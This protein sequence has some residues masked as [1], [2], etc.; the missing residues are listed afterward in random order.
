VR[1][2]LAGAAAGAAVLVVAAVAVAQII[3]GVPNA[4]PR[5]GSPPDIVASGFKLQR[6]AIGDDRLENPA[7]IFARYGYLDD[8]ALQADGQPTKTEPDQ[9]TYLVTKRNPGGPTAGYDYGHR[10]LIQGHELFTPSGQTFKHAYFTRIN[11]DVR[12]PEHRIT[13]LNPLASD[14]TDSGVRSIDGST[15]DPFNGELLFTAEAGNAGGVFG[16]A[17]KWTGTTAPPVKNYDGSMGKAGYEGIHNDKLGNLIIVE[18]VGG[19]NVTD[20]GAAT[21]IKQPNSFVYRFKPKSASD[22]SEGKLQVLQ[23]SVSGTPI[24][25]HNA[26]TDGPQAARDDA[27]G[28]PIKA[29]HSGQS[30]QAKWVTI[31]DTAVDGT[32]GFDAEAAAKAGGV[33]ANANAANKGTPLKRPEN[34]KFV[35]GTDFSSFVFTE[36][37]DTNKIAG[38]YPGAAE[39]AAWGALLRVDLPKAGAD[40]GTVRAIAVGDQT[41][42]SF[43]NITFLDKK[44]ALVG[45]DRGDTL[46]QQ[47]NALDSLWSF[48][49][50][51][52]LNQINADAKRLIAQGR[53]PE[54]TG[55][56]A[57]REIAPTRTHNDG[58]NETT[59]IHVSDGS[60]SPDGILGARVPSDAGVGW[61]PWRIF[62]TDQHGSNTT[63]ELVAVGKKQH[64]W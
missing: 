61:S 25:F 35:P 1:R 40:A 12:D 33:G 38:D 43:D 53:D 34:G 62:F 47:A 4:N 5:S 44:T 56:V 45:E 58:D 29:L 8:A 14:A 17:L 18:D 26:A 15:Y 37:G 60:T 23:V 10:F 63:S 32:A 54:A 31:H 39:R 46:H 41:H 36:T 22:L 64:G 50:T 48:D 13:L 49:I 7:G 2:V 9:N 52:P 11:L 55:D 3:S 28:E 27:L 19:G 51:K 16:Q 6:V 59:G 21:V 24:T 57:L 30:L 20:N 42:A